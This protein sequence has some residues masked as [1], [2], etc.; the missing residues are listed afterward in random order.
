MSADI[1]SLPRLVTSRSN[2]K[3][4]DDSRTTSKQSVKLAVV[5]R[6]MYN[7]GRDAAPASKPTVPQLDTLIEQQAQFGRRVTQKNMFG[8]S[9]FFVLQ[10][11][12][13]DCVDY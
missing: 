8:F 13:R 1:F 3:I 12:T 5:Q 10:C 6:A 7:I 9:T 2:E 4:H 11:A